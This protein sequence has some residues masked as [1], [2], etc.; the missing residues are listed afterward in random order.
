M[1]IECMEFKSHP[2]GALLGFAN[3][4]LPKMGIELF[5]CGVFSKNGRRWVS[6]PSREY[7]D[8]ESGEKKY[9]AIMRFSEKSHQEAFSKSALEAMDAWCAKEAG[10]SAADEPTTPHEAL[11]F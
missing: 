7:Q 6:T 10:P 5:G 1:S 4:R 8:P 3:Y 2:S 9:I 11:P